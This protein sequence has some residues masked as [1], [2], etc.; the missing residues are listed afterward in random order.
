MWKKGKMLAACMFAMAWWSIFY[1]ELCFA[2]GTC[3]TVQTA[4]EKNAVG[5]TADKTG[6]GALIQNGGT[7]RAS[8]ILQA[9]NDEIVISSRLLEWCEEKLLDRK[10]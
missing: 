4:E 7:N 3:E 2:D 6:K 9:E 5:Q 10:E 8:G 1:P